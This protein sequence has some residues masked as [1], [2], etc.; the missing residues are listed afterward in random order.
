MRVLGVDPGEVRTGIAISDPSGTI[1]NPLGVI[2]H[3]TRMLDAAQIA[4]FAQEQGAVLIV[5]GQALDEEGLPSPQGRK[6]ARLAEAIRQQT[7]LPVILWDESGST[8]EARQARIQMGAAKRRRQGHLDELAATIILQSFLD[9][10]SV[11]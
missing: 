3:N 2:K 8:Q 6:A 5:V 7:S 4:Q 10:Q 9:A 1:A 11:K